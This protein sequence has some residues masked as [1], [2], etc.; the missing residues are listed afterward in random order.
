[1]ERSTFSRRS[2]LK[3]VGIVS[4]GG[5]LAA[6]TPVATTPPQQDVAGDDQPAAARQNLIVWWGSWTPTESMER[7]ED[8]P[9]PHNKIL[10]VVDDYQA[11]HPG[12]EIE[13][14]RLPSGVDSREWMVAQQTAG[15]VP[16]IMPAAQWII[17]EDVDK[18]WWVTLS[19]F[20]EEP[21]PYIPAGQPGSDHWLDQFYPTPN[22]ML[23]IEGNLYNVAFGINTTWFYYNVDLFDE[24]GISVPSNYAEFL[25]NCQVIKDAGLV[26][27]DFYTLSPADSDAWYRQQIGS[28][29]MERDLAPLVNPDFQFAELSEVAC[30]IRA[31]VYHANLPQFRQWLELWKLNVPY[32]R[33]DWPVQAPDPNRLFLTKKTPVLESGS[34]I[35]PQLE[36]DPLMDFEW[37]TFWAPPLTQE[38]SEFVTDPPTVAPN[39]GTV[40]DNY[41]VS[42]RA[43]KDGVLDTAIDIL[44]FMSH[45][46]NVEK[47]QGE[48]GQ[49]MPNVKGTAVPDRFAEAHKGLVESIGYVTMFQYEI[50]T[51]DLEASELCGK[52]WW[53]YLLDEISIDECIEQNQDAFEGYAQRYIDEQGN[54]CA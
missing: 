45:P 36:I 17:K 34:W 14:I 37:A 31:G 51:M 47:V 1:M 50:V 24:L 44:R 22:T 39:V 46:E 33:A 42:T 2:F 32:R 28:M 27:Y 9:N 20:L 48:I 53:S 52:A 43:R 30:A 7:S 11:E 40:T 25:A 4:A 15:T 54:A 29:I 23:F 12:V 16:H 18:D 5:V 49:N 6:C 38:S 41:A 35:I 10:E 19:P 21:N 26:G 13:W 8:N 3:T